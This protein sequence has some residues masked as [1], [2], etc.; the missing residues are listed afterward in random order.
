MIV[1]SNVSLLLS[2]MRL[3]L[4]SSKVQRGGQLDC[5]IEICD[6]GENCRAGVF[7]E[8]LEDLRSH[9]LWARILI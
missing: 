2:A 6:I 7:F 3:A 5:L 1:A 9:A 8:A 4:A